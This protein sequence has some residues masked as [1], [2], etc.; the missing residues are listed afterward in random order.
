MAASPRATSLRLRTTLLV[1]AAIV[2]VLGTA[3]IVIDIRVDNEV[4]QRADADLLEHAQALADIFTARTK[5]STQPF[6]SYWTPSFLADD[7][8]NYFRIDCRGQH[9]VS[10]DD[11][12][13]LAWPTPAPNQSM[14]FS[15]MTDH[16]GTRLR[17]I[18][19]RFFPDLNAMHDAPSGPD[20][21]N[22]AADATECMLGLAVDHS[23]VLDF[24]HSMD[25]IEFGGVVLGF[26]IVAIL[27]PLLV[28]RSLRPL[29]GL[30]EAMDKIGPETPSMR[31]QGTNIRELAPLIARFNAVL[32][33]MEEGLL[34][35]RQFASSVAHELRTPLA[36]LRTA[37]EVELRY[38][39]GRDPH[40]LLADIGEIGAKMERIVTALLLLTR[41]EAGIEQLSLQRVDVTALTDALVIR[42]QHRL[43]ER[44]LNLRLDIE[45]SVAWMADS[46]LL[47][48]L[49]GNLLSN[50]IA[51]A[52][53]GSTIVLCSAQSNWS[54]TNA[55]PDLTD[56]DI[57]RMKQRFWRKGKDAGVHT[58]L[59]L[60]LAASAA[61]AQSLRLELV[62]REGNLQ[63]SVMP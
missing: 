60:A 26:L 57:A 15:D 9:V 47:D 29:A 3:M 34:R 50:A 43:R 56:E 18:V 37:I 24:Q 8:T 14:D 16:R 44:A 36:E 61:H 33:R 27:T 25:R 22:E 62:L 31:L 52:P 6:P 51:Y 11:V 12:R 23:E 2:V 40:V 32:S 48:V 7:G 4:A 21:A 41:I 1:I 35:E 58:G 55:A 10:S 30:A 53:S 54:V 17:A 46:T 20:A 49:L 5:A 28:M 38:P 59:G 63:A 45:P 19:L 42:H 39:S 13:S